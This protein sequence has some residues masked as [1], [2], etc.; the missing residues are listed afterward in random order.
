MDEHM[1]EGIGDRPM[2]SDFFAS[3]IIQFTGLTHLAIVQSDVICNP[4][5]AG[6]TTGTVARSAWFLFL[7]EQETSALG[8]QWKHPE[9]TRTARSRR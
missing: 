8:K 4:A 2:P 6:D 9:L 1:S 3:K 7:R 5:D